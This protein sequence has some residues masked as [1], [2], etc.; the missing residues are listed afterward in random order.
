MEKKCVRIW[1]RLLFKAIISFLSRA[2]VKKKNT[3]A[4]SQEPEWKK[5]YCPLTLG[6]FPP[7]GAPSGGRMSEGQ[8][9]GASKNLD[10]CKWL[11]LC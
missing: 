7:E 9:G 10:F 6:P 8:E 2:N 1:D 4:R 11:F 3:G 5:S